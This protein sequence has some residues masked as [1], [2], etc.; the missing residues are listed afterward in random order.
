MAGAELPETADGVVEESVV[1]ESVVEDSVV[2]D[3]PLV[4]GAGETVAS[5]PR[6]DEAGVAASVVLL[7]EIAAVAAG[8][9][10]TIVPSPCASLSVAP[11]GALRST[12]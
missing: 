4:V 2:E 1:E 5:D 11:T 9:L 6:A 8:S 12:E 3:A 7:A 10:S